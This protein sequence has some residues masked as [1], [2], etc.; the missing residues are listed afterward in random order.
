[1][2]VVKGSDERS[3]VALERLGNTNWGCV[4]AVA[5]ADVI[6]EDDRERVIAAVEASGADHWVDV[7]RM[8]QRTDPLVYSTKLASIPD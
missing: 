7:I 2:F 5:L 1:M 8:D 3:P 6:N 4:G